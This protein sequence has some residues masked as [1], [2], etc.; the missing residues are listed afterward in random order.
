M[1]KNKSCHFSCPCL[2]PMLICCLTGKLI[3]AQS[4][5]TSLYPL[6]VYNFLKY[7][8]FP[9][10]PPVL[11][12]CI[13]GDKTRLQ[14]FN[15]L[16]EN[17]AGIQNIEVFFIST[18]EEAIGFQAVFVG[19]DRIAQLPKLVARLSKQPVLLITQAADMTSKGALV[20]FKLTDNKLKFQLNPIA[21]QAAGLRMSGNLMALAVP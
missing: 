20:S 12:V 15:K 8:E 7:T 16:N 13:L 1:I 6:F 21:I 17:K 18:A 10:Q 19:E 9:S 3:F 4:D 14:A 11:R 5:P 2:M